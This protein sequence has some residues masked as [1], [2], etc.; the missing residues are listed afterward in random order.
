VIETEIGWS[1]KE[2]MPPYEMVRVVVE[3]LV[4]C[5][6]PLGKAKCQIFIDV[7]ITISIAFIDKIN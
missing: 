2:E 4:F 6:L 7:I 1:R 5:C 3:L